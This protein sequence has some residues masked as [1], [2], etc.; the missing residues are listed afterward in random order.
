MPSVVCREDNSRAARK[1]KHIWTLP[2]AAFH[3]NGPLR[4]LTLEHLVTGFLIEVVRCG[5]AVSPVERR[6]LDTVLQYMAAHL[7]EPLSIPQ[8]A[9]LALLSVSHFKARF[10]DE[11]GV[12]PAEFQ[13]RA[14]VAEARRLLAAGRRTVTEVA[15]DLGFSSSQYFAT[16]FKRFTGVNPGACLPRTNPLTRVLSS[17]SG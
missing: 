16:V 14:R 11:L 3:E 7:D 9:Q 6:S 15:F 12:P 10:K 13:M 1:C 5:S 17:L 2:R 8:L 4:A